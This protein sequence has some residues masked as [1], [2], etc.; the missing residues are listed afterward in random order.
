MIRLFFGPAP[1]SLCVAILEALLTKLSMAA[2]TSDVLFGLIVECLVHRPHPIVA[3]PHSRYV[4]VNPSNDPMKVCR[5]ELH[6]QPQLYRDRSTNND[7]RYAR[8]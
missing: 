1:S 2:V 4:Q 7:L 8:H 6:N 5:T 3:V